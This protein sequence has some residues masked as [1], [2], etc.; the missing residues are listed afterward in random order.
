MEFFRF[1]YNPC[2]S[3][4][5]M[6]TNGKTGLLKYWKDSYNTGECDQIY[7]KLTIHIVLLLV[8]NSLAVSNV[9]FQH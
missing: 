3:D 1:S 4:I 2:T 7:M 5:N 6:S 8:F 9:C